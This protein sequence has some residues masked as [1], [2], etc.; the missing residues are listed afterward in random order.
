MAIRYLIK[1]FD[2][3]L[4]TLTGRVKLSH[5]L[6][7]IW[8]IYLGNGQRQSNTTAVRAIDASR[9]RALSAP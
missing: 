1:R 2:L 3:E 4:I 5:R 8:E 9:T 6:P 7:G